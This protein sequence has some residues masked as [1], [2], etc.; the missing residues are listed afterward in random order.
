MSNL[1]SR[2]FVAVLIG[3][4][5]GLSSGLLIR[6]CR[7]NDGNCILIIDGKSFKSSTLPKINSEKRIQFKTE[8]TKATIPFEKEIIIKVINHEK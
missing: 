3:I 8:D 4:S 7:Y 6:Q 1:I 2:C 5:I